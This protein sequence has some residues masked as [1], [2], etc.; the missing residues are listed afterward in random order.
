MDDPVTGAKAALKRTEGLAKLARETSL[1][2]RT[3]AR[4]PAT[5]ARPA[6]RSTEQPRGMRS[7]VALRRSLQGGGR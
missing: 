3:P 5:K 1:V 7:N 6:S 2:P 4:A